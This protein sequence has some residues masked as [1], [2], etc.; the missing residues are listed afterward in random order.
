METRPVYLIQSRSLIDVVAIRLG[1][2]TLLRSFLLHIHTMTTSRWQMPH[3]V[4]FS[5]ALN[6]LSRDFLNF[7]AS[8]GRHEL[9]RLGG[10]FSMCKYAEPYPNRRNI[11]YR[12]I[13]Y[14]DAHLLKLIMLQVYSLAMPCIVWD[15][16]K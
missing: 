7:G 13:S 11:C 16:P 1:G 5:L 15:S 12:S 4:P 8:R 14:R 9:S 2:W 10:P 6:R 3:F